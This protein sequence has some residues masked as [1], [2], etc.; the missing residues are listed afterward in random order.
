MFPHIY[1]VSLYGHKKSL[2]Q[3]IILILQQC[4]IGNNIRVVEKKMKIII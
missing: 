1:S 3:D 4:C 2:W